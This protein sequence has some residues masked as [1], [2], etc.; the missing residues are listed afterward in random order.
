MIHIVLK[1][2][3]PLGLIF[4][5]RCQRYDFISVTSMTNVTLPEITFDIKV[6]FPIEFSEYLLSTIT[7]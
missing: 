3:L 7:N 4:S 6:K 1:S 5:S 2:T